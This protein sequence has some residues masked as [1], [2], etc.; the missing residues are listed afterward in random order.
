MAKAWFYKEYGSVDVLQF[1]EIPSPSAGPGQVLIE[2]RAA[3]LNPVDFKLRRSRSG[4]TPFPVVPGADVAGVVAEVGQGVSKFKKG[5]EVYADVLKIT[6]G[7]P[8][9][10]G[11]LAEYTVAEEHL[12]ALKP[13]NLSFEE[14]ASLPLA[15]Q[16]ALLAFDTV[17]F[18]KG[19]SVFIVGGA[20]GVGTLAIQLAK[21]VFE[22]S[23]I[24]STSSTG[25]VE[26][27]R[28][29]GADLVVDYTKQSYEQIDE[30][31]D[32]V[33]D[34]IGESFKSHV[35]AKDEGKIVDIA[36]FPP[37]QKAVNVFVKPKGSDLERVGK[38]IES[39][40]LKPVID[41]KS[42]YAFSDVVEAFKH[43][44]SGR[45]RGKIVISPID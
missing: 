15:L 18:Q 17:N 13:S 21:H 34:T 16:T 22:A 29:L 40:K 39:G 7:V 32:F 33:F 31:F 41:P 26:F 25:K 20:G 30:K 11:T 10:V 4:D 42:P 9:Q 28:S 36:T 1:G 5:D 14:A 43:L 24:V 3:A 35:V 12:L 45:A 27:V 19:Q 6:E 23:R 8:R 37:H 44:E 2:V 38:Y